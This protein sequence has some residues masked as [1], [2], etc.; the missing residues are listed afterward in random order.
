M[1]SKR[2]LWLKTRD[3]GVLLF[4]DVAL[5]IQETDKEDK[6][7]DEVEHTE[8]NC[9]LNF[10]DKEV[11]YPHGSKFFHKD[12]GVFCTVTDSTYDESGKLESIKVRLESLDSEAV[13]TNDEESLK[14]LQSHL[15]L[16][17]RAVQKSGSKFTIEGKYD[18]ATNLKENLKSIFGA[19]GY[20]SQS[21]KIFHGDKLLD[22]NQEFASIFQPGVDTYLYAFESQGKPKKWSRFPQVYEYGTWSCGGSADA[23]AFIT[24]KPLSIAGFVVYV[25][26]EEPEFDLNYKISVDGA[27][28]EE[29][30]TKKYKDYEDTY[31][32]TIMLENTYAVKA[33]A[34]I[35]IL[36]RIAKDLSSSSYLYTY[37]GTDGYNYSSV[38]NEHMGLFTVDYGEGGSNGTSTS[39][40]QIPAILYY[41]D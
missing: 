18:L 33:N 34:K 11:K 20:N 14:P 9:V 23:I 1:E 36:V 32:K 5:V 6:K 21:F 2:G 29:G 15:D 30:P 10:T 13:L 8:E 26:K 31:Y 12:M 25:P 19:V 41:L 3:D 37:Y 38:Q 22:A 39:S 40:G 4:K 28:L 17:I 27:T 16:Y 35:N 7:D 24:T